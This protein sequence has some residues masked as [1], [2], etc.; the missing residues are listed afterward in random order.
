MFSGI[1]NV[2][3]VRRIPKV[4]ALTKDEN[5]QPKSYRK[6]IK[7]NG[8]K[9]LERVTDPQG[10]MVPKVERIRGAKGPLLEMKVKSSMHNPR[11]IYV[12]CNDVAVFL[13]AFKKKTQKLPKKDIERSENRY[14]DLK[15]RGECS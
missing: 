12:D 13:D 8:V 9:K 1:P 5:S 6:F 4:P 14:A 10:E 15:S 11:F 3:Q 7:T 2:K